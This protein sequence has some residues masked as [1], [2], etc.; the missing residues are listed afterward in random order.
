[1]KKATLRDVATQ[2]GLHPVTVSRMLGG[3]YAGSAETTERVR[4][5]AEELGYRTS[6]FAKAMRGRSLPFVLLS[7]NLDPYSMSYMRVLEGLLQEHG[8]ALQVVLD[9]NQLPEMIERINPVATVLLWGEL[10]AHLQHLYT[11]PDVIALHVEMPA[12]LAARCFRLQMDFGA[13][14]ADLARHL[15]GKGHRRCVFL[16]CDDLDQQPMY[17]ERRVRFTDTLCG[18]DPSARV[19]VLSLPRLDA[20]PDMLN[21]VFAP[22]G[23]PT[24]LVCLGDM[25]AWQA[26]YHFC[27][28]GVRVP[29]DVSVTGSDGIPL[30]HHC[31]RLTTV[32]VDHDAVALQIVRWITGSI[33]PAKEH[34]QDAV[35][36]YRRL[37]CFI[38]QDASVAPPPP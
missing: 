2:V 29:H 12:G 4:R 27:Q 8:L 33:A 25:I 38:H 21:A 26:V 7:G 37:P 19:Q 35:A 20:L 6:I 5:V 10:E 13:G 17:H 28:I 23:R 30:L 36:E 31:P 34:K 11:R 24:A 22:S 3:T 18:L 14:F 1:M 32:H 16:T 15:H 9:R